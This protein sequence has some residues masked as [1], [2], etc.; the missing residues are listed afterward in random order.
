MIAV[1]KPRAEGEKP[2]LSI[3]WKLREKEQAN[4]TKR[5]GQHSNKKSGIPQLCEVEN[6]EN[7]PPQ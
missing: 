4:A 6:P 5:Q 7:Q 3:E 1:K 2:P